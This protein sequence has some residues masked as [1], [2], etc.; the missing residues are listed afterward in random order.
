MKTETIRKTLLLTLIAPKK[1]GTLFEAISGA[2]KFLLVFPTIFSQKYCLLNAPA[3][4]GAKKIGGRLFF[5]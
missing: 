3:G 4:R 2:V 1:F 5:C